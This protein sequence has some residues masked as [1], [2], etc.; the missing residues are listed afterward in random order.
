MKPTLWK[1]L[2]GAILAIV[3]GGVLPGALA[4]D[5]LECEQALAHL[6]ECCPTIRAP[7]VCG[8]GC[9]TITLSLA[10]S[11]CIQD[12]SCDEIL[13]SNMCARVASLS[14]SAADG[15]LTGEEAVC[16]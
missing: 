14:N 6:E 3:L 11:E 7:L 12:S 15:T 5:Q 2:R 16:P 9:G 4:E 13:A 10:S 1:T 8:D